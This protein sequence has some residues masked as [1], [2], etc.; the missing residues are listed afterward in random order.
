MK[1]PGK[2]R[3]PV[4]RQGTENNS[5]GKCNYYINCKFYKHFILVW[6]EGSYN[7]DCGLF[8]DNFL[9]NL[10]NSE[11]PPEKCLIVLNILRD[12]RVW[13]GWSLPRTFQLVILESAGQALDDVSVTEIN[14]H[15]S[16]DRQILLITLLIHRILSSTTQSI[17]RL[18]A[19]LSKFLEFLLNF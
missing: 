9:F 6:A 7:L 10:L 16:G 3:S 15:S 19:H 1:V 18:L 4:L 11:H 12:G 5:E 13:V 8:L 2:S 17:T 14:V